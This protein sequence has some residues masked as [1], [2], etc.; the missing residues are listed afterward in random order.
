[1]LNESEKL[2]FDQKSLL[3]ESEKLDCDQGRLLNE[4]EKIDFDL[5]Y[6]GQ[7]QRMVEL[8]RVKR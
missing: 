2:D 1:V 8:R 6:L 3:H 4:S 5:A 7:L